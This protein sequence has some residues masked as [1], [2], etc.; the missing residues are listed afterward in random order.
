M[1]P[2]RKGQERDA[3]LLVSTQAD[4]HDGSVVAG[5]NGLTVQRGHGQVSIPGLQRSSGGTT[6]VQMVGRSVQASQRPKPAPTALQVIARETCRSARWRSNS[7][8]R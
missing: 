1:L 2:A 3:C 5:F 8:S 4:Q 7:A 6:E